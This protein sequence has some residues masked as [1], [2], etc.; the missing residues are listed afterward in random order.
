MSRTERSSCEILV[1]GQRVWRESCCWRREIIQANVAELAY[2]VMDC[3]KNAPWDHGFVTTL[4]GVGL[5]HAT[6]TN[7]R[8]STVE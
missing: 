3:A 8:T 1:A 4:A 5:N 6:S 7:P 2:C